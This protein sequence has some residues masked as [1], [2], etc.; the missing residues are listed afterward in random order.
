MYV[1]VTL[2][3]VVL[4]IALLS[5]VLLTLPPASFRLMRGMADEAERLS[6]WVDMQLLDQRL[7]QVFS[8]GQ[9]VEVS[10]HRVVVQ[11][12]DRAA[13]LVLSTDGSLALAWSDEAMGQDLALAGHVQERSGVPAFAI[14]DASGQSIVVSVLYQSREFT[15]TY[16]AAMVL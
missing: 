13:S 8:C 14:A 3:E 7:A 12:I 6:V 4:Y 9:V 11:C 5:G 10:P 1:G 15:K 2:L 16:Y